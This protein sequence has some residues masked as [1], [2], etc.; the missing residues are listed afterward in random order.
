M[1]LSSLVNQTVAAAD[2]CTVNGLCL[3]SRQLQP[4]E[5]F[6]ALHGSQQHGMHHAA[7]AIANG[8]CAIV[9]EPKGWQTAQQWPIPTLAIDNLAQQLGAFA[10]R[11]YGQPSQQLA[12][13]GITGTNGKTS[14]SHFIAQ[15]LGNCGIIGT[16]GWG[17]PQQL[18][19]SAN[20]TPDAVS[21]QQQL[22]HFVAHGKTAVAMEVS[23]HGLHGGRVNGIHFH[24][25]V[26]T[27]LSRDHLDYHGTMDA[28][29]DAKLGLFRQPD[30]AFAVINAD[31]AAA[32][33][34]LAA[35]A[36][37]V[38]RWCFS[39]AN[40]APCGDEQ[41]SAQTIHCTANGMA[42]TVQ[43]RQQTLDAE[44]NLRGHFNVANALA[45]LAVLL[46]MDI[47]FETAVARLAS[48]HAVPGRMQGL[49]GQ[50]L[51]RVWI[52]YAHTPDAL[53]QSLQAAKGNGQLWLVFGCGGNRDPGK[54]PEMGR[55]AER[56]ADCIIITDDNPR[57]ENPVDIVNAIL[58]G[59]HSPTISV[60]HNRKT[61]IEC[62]VAQAS[63][64][65]CI[66]IAGKG[67]EH[68]QDIAGQRLPFSDYA[69]AQA[70]LAAREAA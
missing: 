40:A 33:S 47:P 21:L 24:G 28:Y 61:A 30:L 3:D 34:V 46:A 19:P 43:W 2:D 23:S 48:L 38:K 14:C 55:I 44:I 56:Y 64:N 16:L 52:D 37:G 17:D 26:F 63:A 11:F 60:I 58:A 35:V 27:N 50:G 70:A 62:A 49:G 20:T 59:C 8:A 57:H 42:F 39:M 29:L 13:I 45:V 68:Y 4:G 22:Q 15:A 18:Q 31:D 25:A 54:R 65:D 53:E 66:L 12:V 36:N 10:S 32:N 6:I 51:P 69:I 5:L 9:Y 1:K 7:Q 67:H 41:L